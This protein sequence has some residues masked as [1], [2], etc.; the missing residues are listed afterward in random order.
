M[1]SQRHQQDIAISIQARNQATGQFEKA[2][3]EVRD[4]NVALQSLGF[5]TVLLDRRV[6]S[7]IITLGRMVP[8]IRQAGDTARGA[9]TGVQGSARGAGLS[10]RGLGVSAGAAAP[11]L[12]AVG[13]AAAVA[14][15]LLGR[16]RDAMPEEAVENAAE[17][18]ANY[19]RSVRSLT[20]RLSTLGISLDQARASIRNAEATLS[21][22]N[23]TAFLQSAES[24]GI[25]AS[26]GDD[27]QRAVLD[28]AEKAVQVGLVAPEEIGKLSNAL[29]EAR[30]GNL[31]P[32]AATLGTTADLIKREFGQSGPE[33][34]S[35]FN[36]ALGDAL[37]DGVTN[38]EKLQRIERENVALTTELVGDWE[39]F[40]LTLDVIN[41]R[42]D[43][44]WLK[45]GLRLKGFASD[46]V[47]W[48]SFALGEVVNLITFLVDPF[49]F[50]SDTL[51]AIG[52]G[53]AS[54]AGAVS[55]WFASLGRSISEAIPDWDEFKA[56]VRNFVDEA[57][58]AL[59]EFA[60][61]FIKRW[62]QNIWSRITNTFNQL[63]G[64]FSGLWEDIRGIFSSALS[65]LINMIPSSIRD[66]F[67]GI[68]SSVPGFQS[69]GMVPGPVGQPVP[70]I[71][72]GGERVIPVGG[73]AG[74]SSQQPLVI[75]LVMDSRV[76][77]EVAIN[78]VDNHAKFM[79]GMM[80]G[81]IG[82]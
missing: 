59:A 33:A 44:F 32:L 75:Q 3:E 41:A 30:D 27:A 69:G 12:G 9:L 52:R 79:A 82:S 74:L 51:G 24:L 16:V 72:H 7:L 21:R 29:L 81:T 54:V 63:R 78:A 14:A 47:R 64:F 77:G 4:F 34:V 37:G 55:R 26:T 20:I 60:A 11:A 13:A 42:I 10:L 22:A 57:A 31:E 40:K 39:D 62:A 19:E 1:T 66:F 45:G 15:I 56:A 61:D 58:A 35:S 67:S 80:P 46:V 38:F 23:A 53:I 70:A 25:I 2:G 17:A 36:N 73:N 48:Y 65:G 5:T 18:N 68:T 76:I 50:I 28:I 6:R 8:G 71:L 49:N 43:Q